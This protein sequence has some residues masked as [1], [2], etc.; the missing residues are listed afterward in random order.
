MLSLGEFWQPLTTFVSK[1][2][3]YQAWNLSLSGQLSVSFVAV[4]LSMAVFWL[5][6]SVK[7]LEARRWM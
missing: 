6:L 4:Y 3:F 5:F 2:D 1:F 7:V